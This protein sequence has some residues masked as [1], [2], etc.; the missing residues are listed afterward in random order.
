MK[1]HAQENVLENSGSNLSTL[2]VLPPSLTAMVVCLFAA[3]WQAP[4]A[5]FFAFSFLSLLWGKNWRRFC[6]TFAYPIV[7]IVF[8]ALIVVVEVSFSPFAIG[9][10]PNAKEL[11]VLTAARP[12][13]CMACLLSIILLVPSWRLF[14]DL[15]RYG[16]PEL[17]SELSVFSINLI[18][19]AGRSFWRVGI[20]QSSRLG[21]HSFRSS[22]QCLSFLFFNFFI[23]AFRQAETMERALYSRGY[24]G[25]LKLMPVQSKSDLFPMLS[26]YG[27]TIFVAVIQLVGG[28]G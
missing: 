16:M 2:A 7:F 22:V 4:M 19:A 28:G 24:Q 27:A 13:G 8:G 1:D 9:L 23:R 17:I 14:S 11:Y 12:L 3:N 20:A 18:E 25:K 15:S 10:A 5:A 21:G 26:L 6:L